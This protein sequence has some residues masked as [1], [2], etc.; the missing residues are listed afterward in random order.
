MRHLRSIVHTC[1]LLMLLTHL[2]FL[3]GCSVTRP[4]KAAGVAHQI[5]GAL[6]GKTGTAPLTQ[7]QLQAIVMNFADIYVMYTWEAYNEIRRSATDP[8]TRAWAQYL[9]VFSNSNAMTIA[10]GRNAVVNLLDML[11]FVSLD[12]YAIENYWM[13]EVL[14][15]RAEPLVKTYREIEK[16]IWK[17]SARVLSE[18]QQKT[19]HDLIRQWIAANP[20]QHYTAAVRLSDF[21]ELQGVSHAGQLEVGTLLA[22]VEK[23]VAVAEEGLLLSERVMFFAERLPR[24]ITMQTELILAQIAVEP[25][26]EQLRNNLNRFTAASE[27]LSLVA[28]DLPKYVTEE[29]QA[30]INQVFQQLESLQQRLVNDLASQESRLQVVFGDARTTLEKLE[31]L[32]DKITTTIQSGDSLYRTIDATSSKLPQYKDLLDKGLIT[33]DKLDGLLREIRP[34]FDADIQQGS[35]RIDPMLGKAM[36]SAKALADH[37]FWLG[38]LLI[39]LFLCGQLAVLVLHR[40]LSTKIR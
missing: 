4:H 6:D 21:A 10:A 2:V 14:G 37:L 27:R 11:V 12:C 20:Q 17:T 30:A 1:I 28:A 29:R 15:S 22:D 23:A 36:L 16:E 35:D 34:L 32:T 33:L 18:A 40:I 13:P 9:K 25:D 26:A 31:L 7:A 38:A 5:N 24:M 8:K 19:L 39:A 3:T